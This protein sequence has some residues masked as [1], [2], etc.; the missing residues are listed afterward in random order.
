MYEVEGVTFKVIDIKRQI[1]SNV[2]SSTT[3]LLF[4]TYKNNAGKQCSEQLL[5]QY[6]SEYGKRMV[7]KKELLIASYFMI[8]EL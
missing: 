7:L 2:L 6:V 5:I 4:Y 8:P 1:F 3:L